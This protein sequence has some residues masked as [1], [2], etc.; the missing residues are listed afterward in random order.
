MRYYIRAE[1]GLGG[2]RGMAL[3][4]FVFKHTYLCFCSLL[5]VTLPFPV[6]LIEVH[7]AV[8]RHHPLPAGRLDQSGT[9]S[10]LIYPPTLDTTPTKWSIPLHTLQTVKQLYP[11]VGD[12]LQHCTHFKNKKVFLFLPHNIKMSV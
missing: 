3:L 11:S 10:T 9:R 4:C 1:F 8:R 5:S 6:P 12:I 7:T 2:G